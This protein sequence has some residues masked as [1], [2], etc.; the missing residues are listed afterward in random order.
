MKI[1]VGSADRVL[2]IVVGLALVGGALSG[3]IGAWG[4]IGLL[5]I[6]TGI[7]R[8]CPA[9]LP[10]GWNTCSIKKFD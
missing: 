3:L 6:A 4:W 2:R 9:Y 5:P 1:N 7:F 8:I 10:F